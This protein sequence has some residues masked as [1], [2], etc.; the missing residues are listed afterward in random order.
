MAEDTGSAPAEAQ[1]P[2]EAVEEP[3]VEEQQEAAQTE[4]EPEQKKHEPA[5]GSPRW[6]EIYKKTKDQE[7]RIAELESMV[8][9]SQQQQPQGRNQPPEVTQIMHLRQARKEAA[10]ALDMAT[11]EEINDQ[12][13]N[14][15]NQLWA[16]H[17]EEVMRGVTTRTSE[18]NAVENFAKQTEWFNETKGTFDEKMAVYAIHLKGRMA[19]SWRGTLPDL[20]EEVKHKTE[21]AFSYQAKGTTQSKKP[22]SYVNSGNDSKASTNAPVTLTAQERET[23][24]LYF[25]EGPEAEKKY[26]TA[27]ARLGR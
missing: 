22:V 19:P 2:Q 12:I 4:G 13:R 5:P 15:E 25:G 18:Q 14:L 10:T 8:I 3:Q 16:K 7:R 27:K 6:N 23:A 24:H 26:A 20:L 21:E 9:S 11:V 1:E 17:N